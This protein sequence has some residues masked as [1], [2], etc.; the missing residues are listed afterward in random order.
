MPLFVVK[1]ENN[2]EVKQ[3]FNET[4]LRSKEASLI[5]NPFKWKLK[6]IKTGKDLLIVCDVQPVIFNFSIFGWVTAFTVFFIWG[7]HWV[8]WLGVLVGMMTYFWTSEFYYHMTWLA[9]R[10]K[11]RYEGSIKRI[12]FSELIREVVL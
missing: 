5:K 10:K 7:L 8:V 4:R 9:L 1:T 6:V 11:A 12:K 2:P 3:W